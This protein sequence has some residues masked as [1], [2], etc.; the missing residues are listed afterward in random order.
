VS[1]IFSKFKESVFAVLPVS[2]IVLVLGLILKTPVDMV[3]NFLIGTVLLILGMTLFSLGAEYA[4]VPIGTQVGASFTKAKSKKLLLL[5]TVSFIIGFLITV[6]EPDLTVLAKQ[7]KRAFPPNTIILSVSAG[8]GIMLALATLRI[9]FQISFRKI[10]VIAYIAI[11]IFAAFIPEEFITIAFDSGGV[12]T[13]PITVPIILALG[14][15]FA[16]VKKGDAMEDSFGLTALCSIGPI[17]SIL[18]LGLFLDTS[19]IKPSDFA[20]SEIVGSSGILNMYLEALPT[21]TLHVAYALAPIAAFFFIYNALMLKLPKKYMIRIVFGLIYLFFG[22]LIFLI[23]VEV[24]FSPFGRLIAKELVVKGYETLLIPIG[25]V[26]GFFIVAAEPAVHILI[27]QVEEISG[28]TI[29]QRNILI[30][31]MIGMSIAVALA[32]VRVLTGISI[33]WLILPGYAVALTLTFFVP[34]VFTAIAFDSGGV[35][36][37]PMTSTFLLPFSIGASVA[38][39]GNILRDAFGTVA[40]VAMTPLLTLQLLGLFSQIKSRKLKLQV[41]TVAE[42]V[43]DLD[44]PEEVIDLDAA[45][46]RAALD[47]GKIESAGFEEKFASDSVK[48]EIGEPDSPKE[49]VDEESAQDAI[50]NSCNLTKNDIDINENKD[51]EPD[52]ENC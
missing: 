1:T 52:N 11:F 5:L 20:L 41:A 18:I 19:S 40:M 16:A 42:D 34:K 48:E 6:A 39:G 25:A 13:G 12:S 22:V 3:A 50:V 30:A 49:A 28:G 45:E 2:V 35:A 26:V 7:L 23:G 9:A 36:S 31:L 46:E 24:G 32:M 37:G 8:V 44:I 33:W 17:A 27:E 38:L 47:S 10:L 43:I 15:G 14:I 29:K 21:T 51:A 4:M